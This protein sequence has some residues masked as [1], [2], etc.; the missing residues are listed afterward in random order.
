MRI[1]FLYFSVDFLVPLLKYNTIL[2]CWTIYASRPT[3]LETPVFKNNYLFVFL[4]VRCL[5]IIVAFNYLG[6]VKVPYAKIDLN[7][8][9]VQRF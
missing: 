7:Q 9:G 3:L 4:L 2:S 5:F 1:Y 8:V 6:R